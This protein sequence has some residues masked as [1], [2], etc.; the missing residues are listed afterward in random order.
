MIYKMLCQSRKE[1]RVLSMLKS[2]ESLF[3]TFHV[4][5]LGKVSDTYEGGF[6]SWKS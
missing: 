3:F 2:V 4:K 1:L 5:L 6:N